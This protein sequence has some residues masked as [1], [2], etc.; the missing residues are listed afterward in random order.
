M[1]SNTD[2]LFQWVA[3]EALEDASSMADK[4]WPGQLT[5]VMP[6]H[7]DEIDFLNPRNRTIGMR[8]PQCGLA[9]MFLQ[10][11]GPLA[12]TSANFSGQNPAINEK[13]AATTFPSLPLLGPLPWPIPSGLASTVILWE[14]PRSWKL[15]RRGALIPEFL[16]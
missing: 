10:E 13:E 15:L 14:K 8:I 3:P 9:R 16:S 1:G 2:Q 6:S 12:T 5:M 4:Y 7:R 11:T